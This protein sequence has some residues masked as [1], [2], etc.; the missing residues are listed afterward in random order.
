MYYQLTWISETLKKALQG[1]E[2]NS[3]WKHG[4]TH[5]RQLEALETETWLKERKKEFSLLKWLM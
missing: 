4:C 3:R 2:N 5:K 1:K